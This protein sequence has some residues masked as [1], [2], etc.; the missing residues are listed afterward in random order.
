[1]RFDSL[2]LEQKAAVMAPEANVLVLAGAG[3]GKTR[4]LIERVAWLIQN[5]ASPYEIVCATF[6]R[7]AAAEMRGRLVD[8]IGRLARQVSLSTLHGLGLR[9]MSRYGECIG[10]RSGSI[11]VYTPLETQT[12]LEHEGEMLGLYVKG[13]WKHGKKLLDGIFERIEAGEPCPE[14]SPYFPLVRCFEAAYRA[15]NAVPYYGL[16]H[17]LA[18]MAEMGKIRE[19]TNWK[20]L[21]VDEAQDLDAM[22]WRAL[23][24]IQKHADKGELYAVGDLSQSIYGFR[25]AVPG[26]LQGMIDDGRLKVYELKSNYRSDK[27]IVD[28][29]NRLIGHNRSYRALEMQAMR[30]ANANTV[31][32]IND[33]DSTAL[34]AWIANAFF[35]FPPT[36]LCRNN[37]MLDKISAELAALGVKHRRIGKTTSALHSPLFVKAHALLKCCANPFDETAFLMC[38]KGLGLSAD[39]YANCRVLAAQ[40]GKSSWQVYL[41]V[42][43]EKDR[44]CLPLASTSMWEVKKWFEQGK[45]AFDPQ[46]G[47]KAE[48]MAWLGAYLDKFPLSELAEYLDWLA[49]VDVQDEIKQWNDDESEKLITLMTCHAAKGLEFPIVIVAGCNEGVLPGKQAI[50]AGE[51][52][53]EDERRIMYVAAT[54]P[55]DL[56]ILAVRPTRKPLS[57]G[58]N[59]DEPASRFLVEMGM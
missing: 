57:G 24:A 11:S 44:A 30:P 55:R 14:D 46:D 2:N 35:A 48:F 17:G 54:R 59:R 58:G 6:T 28:A 12:L 1:M 10:L 51:D 40:S 34:A 15:N 18:H 56:L 42:V 21:L 36:V 50:K 38:H 52:A 45:Y 53:I 31:E 29:A 16:I 8:R 27:A 5:S 7:A 43:E 19:Y 39:G 37:R 49:L 20:Y 23:A 32:V 4:T 26:Y 22:Q 33:M 3:S 9:L 25:G 41:E 13:K 47:D